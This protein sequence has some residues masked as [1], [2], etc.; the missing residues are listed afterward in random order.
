MELF[1]IKSLPENYS[2]TLIIP[3]TQ[4]I[5]ALN[6]LKNIQNQHQLSAVSQ[7]YEKQFLTVLYNTIQYF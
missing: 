6:G 7:L 2:V 3:S 5:I 1:Q 4:Y